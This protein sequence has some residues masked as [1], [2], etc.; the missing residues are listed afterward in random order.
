MISAATG[1]MLF[2]TL[3]RQN[4]LAMAK[5]P[6]GIHI[7]RAPQIKGLPYATISLITAQPMITKDPVSCQDDIQ[8]QVDVWSGLELDDDSLSG[9][10]GAALAEQAIREAVDGFQGDVE[11]ITINEIRWQTQNPAP[12]EDD[13]DVYRVSVDYLLQIKR[14]GS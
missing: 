9:Y 13:R 14:E 7:E 8:I 4:A 12:F 2:R 10:K 11:G 1:L 6:G 5:L 3:V